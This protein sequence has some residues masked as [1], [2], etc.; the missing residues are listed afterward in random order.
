[1][2][3]ATCSFQRMICL[4]DETDLIGGKPSATWMRLSF[5]D[6]MVCCAV[7]VCNIPTGVTL[8]TGSISTW[9][10]YHGRATLKSDQYFECSFHRRDGQ[11]SHRTCNAPSD[12]GEREPDGG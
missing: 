8:V 5:M 3:L 6:P 12:A 10:A 11:E 2:N 1:L 4:L 7:S 9:G